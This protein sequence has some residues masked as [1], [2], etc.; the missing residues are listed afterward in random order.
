LAIEKLER[1]TRLPRRSG[2]DEHPSHL[3]NTLGTA[4]S[5]LARFLDE[6]STSNSDKTRAWDGAVEAF[7]K[8]IALSG[9]VNVDALL[10]FSHRLVLHATSSGVGKSE[11]AG[12]IIRALELLDEADDLI[13]EHPRPG[14]KWQ[15]DVAQ[16]RTRALAWINQELG[17]EY[18]QALKKS[19]DPELGYLCEARL[20]LGSDRQDVAAVQ[21]ALA[22]LREA[23]AAGVHLGVRGIR[24]ELQLIHRDPQARFEFAKALS[25]YEELERI[26]GSSTAPVEQFRHAVLC[27]Q[28]GDYPGGATRFR[29]LRDEI[30]RQEAIPLRLQDFWRNPNNPELARLTQAR[31]TRVVTEWRAEG[32]VSDLNQTIPLRPRHFSPL[33]RAGDVV[34]CAIRFEGNGPLIVPPRFVNRSNGGARDM[35]HE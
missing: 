11:R 18:I 25:L 8:A 28:T 13:A 35:R 26:Q 20:R 33:A 5:R 32:Y 15:E 34:A 31:V 22:V 29:R 7:E 6:S 27:Y 3:Y 23:E 16:Y 12:D 24:L 14:S 10:A 30:R 17:A 4:Y 9:G 19:N 2:R 21:S 1:A